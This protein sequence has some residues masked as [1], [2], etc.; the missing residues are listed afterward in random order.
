MHDTGA[1]QCAIV[2]S[3]PHRRP[4]G[5]VHTVLVA[6]AFSRIARMAPC[7]RRVCLPKATRRQRAR[8]HRGSIV[9]VSPGYPAPVPDGT[10]VARQDSAL[11]RHG[12]GRCVC[13]HFLSSRPLLGQ[14]AGGALARSMRKPAPIFSDQE[15]PPAP[16]PLPRPWPL[17]S[18]GPRCATW[19]P[20]ANTKLTGSKRTARRTNAVRD[21][22]GCNQQRPAEEGGTPDAYKTWNQQDRAW[23]DMRLHESHDEG[24]FGVSNNTITRHAASYTT[25][26]RFVA[27]LG[28][29]ARPAQQV[30]LPGN[31]LQDPSSW[32]APPLCTLKR[33]HGD[34]LQQYDCTE[35]SAVAQPA[36][37]SDAGGGAAA[38]AGAHPQPHAGS[39]DNGNGKLLLPQLDRLHLAFMRSQVSPSASS[40]SQDQQPQHLPKSVIPTQRRVT[41][42]L[43]KNWAPFKVLRQRYAGTR[44]EEQRQL[45]LPQKHKATVADSTLR[46]EMNG[47]EEQADNAKA[48]ELFWKP[49]SWLGT[50]RPTSAN[51]AFDPALWETFISTTLGLEVPTL[52]ALPRLHSSPPAKC[53]CKKFCMD[54]HGDH[55]ST[56]TSH[57]GATKAHDW[58][59]SVLGPL[60]RTAGHLVR[61]QHG[62]T[63]SAGQRRGDVEV[64][65]YL[66]DQARG[67]SLVFDLS[68][69]HDRFGS[70]SHVQQN[71]SLSH[72]QDLDGPMRVAAQRKTNAYRQTYADNQNIS[73]LPAIMSTSNRMHGEFLRLLF[74]QAH[75]GT[76]AHFTA[77]GLPSQRNQSE[78]FRFKRAAFYQGLK[79]KVGLA[80]AKVAALRINLNVQGCSIVAAPMHAPS[81][82]SLLLP[83]LLSHNLPLPRVH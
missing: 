62:V 82:T 45:H 60:F 4:I 40:T 33:L 19:A 78:S 8:V 77:A 32:V 17:A 9:H 42:Q 68:I 24:G 16:E 2:G 35:Q 59:V 13:P 22:R 12:I 58:M 34:L 46:V 1:K 28:T 39:Q 57:S 51:D 69:T 26:A 55:T 38:N 56:C 54:F 63:A 50:I 53:G 74:L 76:E 7:R 15:P 36:L 37:P 21:V 80:A 73:L 5:A 11:S 64:R 20:A 65:S 3:A 10:L 41:E 79:S 25:N 6:E 49:L 18:R 66:R 67:R 81:R 30:W 44:F 43:T 72:P 29:F 70:S 61:T 52:A 71:G 14:V 27:F 75:R 31:D 48:R 47:L 23:V 83:L